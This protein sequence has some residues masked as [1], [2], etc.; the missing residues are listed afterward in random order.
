MDLNI[1]IVQ[2]LSEGDQYSDTDSTVIVRVGSV[3]IYTGS[4]VIVRVGSVVIYTGSTV[5]VRVGL[6]DYW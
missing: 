6:D 4:T 2:W 5:I 1:V 3:I